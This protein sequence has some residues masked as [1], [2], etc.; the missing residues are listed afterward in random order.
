MSPSRVIP[1]NFMSK[2]TK[3]LKLVVEHG[4]I[5]AIYDDALTALMRGARKVQIARASHVE[6]NDSGFCLWSAD[7]SPVG[8][9]KLV[10]FRTRQEALDAERD[11]LDRNVIT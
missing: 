5:R 8:G 10:G 6:P 1:V 11:Y 4:S 2:R 7:M 9:P 3:H